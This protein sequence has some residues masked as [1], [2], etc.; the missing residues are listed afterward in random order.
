[1]MGKKS[2]K[3]V[4]FYPK[5]SEAADNKAI[6]KHLG[7]FAEERNKYIYNLNAHHSAEIKMLK[8]ETEAIRSKINIRP[9]H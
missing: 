2:T 6:L 4:K 7:H 1:M 9:T 8:D 5:K 3:T